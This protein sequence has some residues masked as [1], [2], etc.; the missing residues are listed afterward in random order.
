MPTLREESS[1]KVLR[2]RWLL[3]PFR[4]YLAENRAMV[5][6]PSTIASVDPSLSITVSVRFS[7]APKLVP[8]CLLSLLRRTSVSTAARPRR[9]AGSGDS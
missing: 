5:P 3:V 1:Q 6:P 4:R 9:W 2:R 8:A 7:R